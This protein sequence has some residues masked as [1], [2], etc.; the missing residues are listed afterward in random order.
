MWVRF[1]CGERNNPGIDLE[2]DQFEWMRETLPDEVLHDEARERRPDWA[3]D[4]DSDRTIY[5]GFERLAKLPE[6]IR[7]NLVKHYKS[8]IVYSNAM[9]K[10][11]GE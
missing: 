7:L 1:W 2:F 8:Q 5:Y 10:I 11:L 3:K 6:D 9:L 4:Y